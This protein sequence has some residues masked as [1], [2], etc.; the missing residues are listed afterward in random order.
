MTGN[1]ET[2]ESMS[3]CG[4]DLKLIRRTIKSDY[5]GESSNISSNLEVWFCI[6]SEHK[7]IGN[8]QELASITLNLNCK[9]SDWL[10]GAETNFAQ[11]IAPLLNVGRVVSST[12][13]FSFIE[14]KY[15]ISVLQNLPRI[16]GGHLRFL[17]GQFRF[18]DEPTIADISVDTETLECDI[19]LL[20]SP[21]SDF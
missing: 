13:L 9:L 19:R 3:L 1:N 21:T 5:Y 18:S 7:R 12:E 8:L 17:C 16:E 10:Q 4:G 20:V 14:N 15:G 11:I 6:S 2:I